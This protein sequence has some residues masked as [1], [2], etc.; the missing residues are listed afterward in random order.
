MSWHLAVKNL[1]LARI[2]AHHLRFGEHGT[3]SG[4]PGLPQFHP[5]AKP[6]RYTQPGLPTDVRIVRLGLLGGFEGFRSCRRAS[7]L[8]DEGQAR[9]FEAKKDPRLV[10]HGSGTALEFCQ[11]G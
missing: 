2:E 1:K 3:V 10:R 7:S 8:P 11:G 5:K 4:M 9:S 6:D